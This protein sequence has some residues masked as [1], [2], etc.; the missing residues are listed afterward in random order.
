M[1]YIFN[2]IDYFD[3]QWSGL[4]GVENRRSDALHA[5]DAPVGQLG[6]G[7]LAGASRCGLSAVAGETL[8][9]GVAMRDAISLLLEK[10]VPIKLV[11]RSNVENREG[12]V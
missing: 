6:E 3:V 2:E 7:L 10:R 8:A 4:H 9:T 1:S 12:E 11:S 5:A